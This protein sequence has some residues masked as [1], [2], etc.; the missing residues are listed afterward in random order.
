MTLHLNYISL[1]RPSPCCY[2]QFTFPANYEAK[3]VLWDLKQNADLALLESSGQTIISPSSNSG[4]NNAMFN[5]TLD[6]GDYY[7]Q[8]EAINDPQRN[9]TINFF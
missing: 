4:N 3:I 1:E 2:Y 9:Y 8:V 7:L 5:A 6:A